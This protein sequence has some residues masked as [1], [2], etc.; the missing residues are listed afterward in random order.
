MRDE[1]QIETLVAK[2]QKRVPAFELR[3]V[4]AGDGRVDPYF[5]VFVR[6]KEKHGLEH[7]TNRE[8]IQYGRSTVYPTLVARARERLLPLLDKTDVEALCEPKNNLLRAQYIPGRGH[9]LA[10][11]QLV[12]ALR[13]MFADSV[14]DPLG[15][16]I[17]LSSTTE[18]V[19]IKA[20]C[21]AKECLQLVAA[22]EQIGMVD[23]ILGKMAMIR[24]GGASAVLAP[25]LD[26]DCSR[27][28]I[29]VH[30]MGCF[31]HYQSL[32]GRE[33]LFHEQV[34]PLLKQVIHLGCKPVFSALFDG[35]LPKEA[36]QAWAMT[37]H[38]VESGAC[39]GVTYWDSWERL[40]GGDHHDGARILTLL[41]LSMQ[42]VLD[43]A[44]D[45]E[46]SLSES[47]EET[48]ALKA[49]RETLKTITDR[50]P[51]PKGRYDD[52][53]PED[54]PTEDFTNVSLL[55]DCL[56]NDLIRGVRP[57]VRLFSEVS[58]W[59]K[60][61]EIKISENGWVGQN[62][63]RII[64]DA[65]LLS[66]ELE[67][68]GDACDPL[69][70]ESEFPIRVFETK[71]D[72]SSLLLQ[73]A[74]RWHFVATQDRLPKPKGD[75]IW[76][77]VPPNTHIDLLGCEIDTCLSV[78]LVTSD[79]HEIP[80]KLKIEPGQV[81]L[82]G[83]KHEQCIPPNQFKALETMSP[84][85]FR[86][87]FEGRSCQKVDEQID[88]RKYLFTGR[89]N[90]MGIDSSFFSGQSKSYLLS[91]SELTFSSRWWFWS[92][93]SNLKKP[94]MYEPGMP[95][96]RCL[97]RSHPTLRDFVVTENLDLRGGFL[98]EYLVP[99]SAIKV[100]DPNPSF[101]VR[102]EH[103]IDYDQRTRYWREEGYPVI[104]ID[105]WRSLWSQ[106][107]QPVE[108]RLSFN[109]SYNR[110]YN[111]RI[112][113][114]T[115]S[116][117]S[118]SVWLMVLTLGICLLVY[119]I[120]FSKRMRL[121]QRLN[122]LPYSRREELSIV[123]ERYKWHALP[124]TIQNYLHHQLGELAC[125]QNLTARE[126]RLFLGGSPEIQ[127][128]YLPLFG[129]RRHL[130]RFVR[131]HFRGSAAQKRQKSND[132]AHTLSSAF[133]SWGDVTSEA[134]KRAWYQRMEP[135]IMSMLSLAVK[136][137]VHFKSFARRF[138]NPENFLFLGS[139]FRMSE[140]IKQQWEE[141][142]D[143]PHANNRLA[144]AYSLFC[145]VYRSVSAEYYGGNLGSPGS[146]RRVLSGL[147][148]IHSF[149]R[150]LPRLQRMLN[151]ESRSTPRRTTRQVAAMRSPLFLTDRPAQA[152][153]GSANV[154][155]TAQQS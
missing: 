119:R 48:S 122:D 32:V 76:L 18:S 70:N 73:A 66:P 34:M 43:K 151:A 78:V 103:E 144:K 138:T 15:Q 47:L 49:Q 29:R 38:A 121:L 111:P 99:I 12:A 26:Q 133:S 149:L 94:D 139:L 2:M 141:R 31:E 96:W 8:I 5:D 107:L 64:T 16:R 11:T 147:R 113:Y 19:Q 114:Y 93:R 61:A 124:K 145:G 20:V 75:V 84:E 146:V 30:L 52:Y 13:F 37:Y 112:H 120:R 1:P 45:G 10:C 153:V 50:L 4:G 55:L 14:I 101:V 68:K 142:D 129:H 7:H 148:S 108:C 80:A 82:I 100:A 79:T 62:K 91:S 41:K 54:D 58:E 3:R 23:F 130:D 87:T 83:L 116:Y 106:G 33:L 102:H 155:T 86:R 115:R 27:S 57:V 132:I 63:V 126:R 131:Q 128:E 152:G 137:R 24:R 123:F 6:L 81:I 110:Y 9:G 22:D 89:V 36:R 67:T 92:L 72:S 35:S 97:I 85:Q 46:R 17:G 140:A 59:S 56:L 39:P 28:E 104:D 65:R 74:E 21:F 134:D 95:S 125:I 109:R 127:A 40:I 118:R 150:R 154:C 135:L 69:L 42:N 117:A 143:Y 71:E 77:T 51:P 105:Y 25:D 98:A 90:L 60:L 53:R 136:K 44:V 88:A